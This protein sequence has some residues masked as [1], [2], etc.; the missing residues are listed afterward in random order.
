MLLGLT[1]LPQ[2]L[3]LL[4]H[5]LPG[6]EN[7]GA[8]DQLPHELPPPDNWWEPWW[9]PAQS[10]ATKAAA[11]DC[12]AILQTIGKTAAVPTTLSP[13][14]TVIFTANKLKTPIFLFD[15]INH[16]FCTKNPK[17]LSLSKVSVQSSLVCPQGI[18]R[19]V[20]AVVSRVAKVMNSIDHQ[21]D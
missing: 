11:V 2:K 12:T 8:P 19:A 5:K 6:Q 17:K 3:L 13:L 18:C 20:N 10:A 16:F 15:N 14:T 1:L 7:C 9:P 21:W 4:P